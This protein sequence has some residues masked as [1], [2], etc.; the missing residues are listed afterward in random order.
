[1]RVCVFTSTRHSYLLIV[2][3]MDFVFRFSQ[4]HAPPAVMHHYVINVHTNNTSRIYT[5]THTQQHTAIHCNTLQHT[6]SRCNT[7]RRR[8]RKTEIAIETKEREI[9]RERG[10]EKARDRA[11]ARKSEHQKKR[12]Q[13]RKQERERACARLR[14]KAHNALQC[15]TLHYTALHRARVRK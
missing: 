3:K 5:H 8:G 14:E 6:V 9:D 11:P 2:Q 13:E 1:V 7:L 10:K 12:E 4:Q 15:I